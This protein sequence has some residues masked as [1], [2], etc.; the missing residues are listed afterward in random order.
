MAAGAEV[1]D[2]DSMN[3]DELLSVSGGFVPSHPSFPLTRPLVR[4]LGS[5]V[6]IPMLSM[7]NAEDHHTFRGAVAAQLVSNNDARWRPVTRKSC[8]RN[9]S[10]QT[11]PA[12][13]EQEYR[14]QH[15]F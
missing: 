9:G 10:R 5:I 4:V 14:R 1:R 13:V 3:L 2:H 7:S 11:G 12:S 6:Q 8:E 15:P